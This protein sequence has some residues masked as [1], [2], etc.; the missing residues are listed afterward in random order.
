MV[1]LPWNACHFALPCCFSDLTCIVISRILCVLSDLIQFLVV[2]VQFI[3]NVV[4]SKKQP[5]FN[6]VPIFSYL[7]SYLRSETE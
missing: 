5:V 1:P 6:I 2:A 7:M 3:L 4:P